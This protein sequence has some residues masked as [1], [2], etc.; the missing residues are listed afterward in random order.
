MIFKRLANSLKSEAYVNV[1]AWTF[2]TTLI[3]SHYFQAYTATKML[4]LSGSS[5]QS[6]I[7]ASATL[8][9]VI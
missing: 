7:L 6:V 9:H 3:Q 1:G 4:K 2:H 5:R 8:L